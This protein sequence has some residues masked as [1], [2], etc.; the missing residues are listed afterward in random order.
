M[1]RLSLTLALLLPFSPLM[2]MQ[3]ERTVDSIRQM[4]GV[5]VVTLD[6]DALKPVEKI[7]T[8]EQRDEITIQDLENPQTKESREEDKAFVF[9]GHNINLAELKQYLFSGK[10]TQPDKRDGKRGVDLNSLSTLVGLFKAKPEMQGLFDLIKVALQN[11][12]SNSATTNDPMQQILDALNKMSQ[13]TSGSQLTEK[14]KQS[15]ALMKSL[16]TQLVGLTKTTN[17]IQTNGTGS[18]TKAVLKFVGDC[19]TK[20]GTA[21]ISTT[22]IIVVFYFLK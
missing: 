19:T 12:E 11:Q 22:I 17:E 20:I 16:G 8:S 6:L 4:P 9:E 3:Q 15:M 18:N 13:T 10:N 21:L 14:E 2:A 1:K 5:K 7:P